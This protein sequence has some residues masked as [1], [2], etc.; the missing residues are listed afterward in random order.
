MAWGMHAACS[1]VVR[2]HAQQQ[3]QRKPQLDK[4]SS[5]S[6]VLAFRA[7]GVC[8]LLPSSCLSSAAFV[9]PPPPMSLSCSRALLRMPSHLHVVAS[10]WEHA[11]RPHSI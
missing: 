4:S 1:S 11:P 8:S 2:W 10:A 7:A 3:L 9:P 6:R 5:S